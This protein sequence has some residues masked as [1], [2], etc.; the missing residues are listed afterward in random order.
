MSK[1]IL[2]NIVLS[3]LMACA[4]GLQAYT[5]VSP[6]DVHARLVRCDTML[7]LDVREV[8][9]YRNGHLAEPDGQLPLTPVNMPWNSHV[10]S[11]EYARLPQN[12]DILVYCGSGGRSASSS[13]F[14]E[15]KGFSRVFNMTGGF[16]F[17]PF[18]SRTEGFGDHSGRWISRSNSDPTIIVCPTTADTNKIVFPPK[19]L[20][21]S[22]SLYVELHAASSP[23]QGPPGIPQTPMDGLFRVTIL[24]RFGLSVCTGD[25]LALKDTISFQFFPRTIPSQNPSAFTDFGLSVH[26]PDQGWK[27]VPCVVNGFSF[28]LRETVLRKWY[29]VHGTISSDVEG[30]ARSLNQDIRLFPNPFNG[31]IQIDAPKGGTIGVFDAGGRFVEEIHSNRWNPD[32][33]VPSGIYFIRY[34]YSDRVITQKAVFLK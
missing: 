2:L 5:N 14:L 12:I 8:S 30:H 6:D 15:S 31:S 23:S 16:S 18:E 4:S 1:P 29:A 33:A 20:P 19:A 28:N 34:A 24:D 3:G 17:W 22:D 25:S 11:A 13:T 7:L 10:L 26:V 9:E 27:S 21:S 32:P